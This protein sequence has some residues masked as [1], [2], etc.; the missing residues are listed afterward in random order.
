MR[1]SARLPLMTD[2]Q[3]Y[4]SKAVCYHRQCSRPAKWVHPIVEVPVCSYH[5]RGRIEFFAQ[6]GERGDSIHRGVMEVRSGRRT[7][8]WA[9]MTLGHNEPITIVNPVKWCAQCGKPIRPRFT[10][11]FECA[12]N[13]TIHHP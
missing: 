9:G 4:Y 1:K 6:E 5:K 11:C 12:E 3:P 10:L 8:R 13:D 2:I 7:P